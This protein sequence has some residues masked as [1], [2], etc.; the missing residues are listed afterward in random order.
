MTLSSCWK[1][2]HSNNS[3]FHIKNNLLFHQESI[4]GQSIDQLYTYQKIVDIL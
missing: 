1:L 2:A 3:G 4:V